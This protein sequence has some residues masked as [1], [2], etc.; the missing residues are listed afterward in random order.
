MYFPIRCRKI[1]DEQQLQNNELLEELWQIWM[2]IREF[3]EAGPALPGG[4]EQFGDEYVNAITGGIAV[5][6]WHGEWLRH[7]DERRRSIEMAIK[8]IVDAPPKRVE[9]AREHDVSTWTWDCFL[10]ET[11][12]ML[13]ARKPEDVCWRHLVAN[14]RLR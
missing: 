9:F 1:L 4:E 10:A 12:A 3:S 11:A 8:T 6:L 2:R 7:H 5:F 14:I 13:W